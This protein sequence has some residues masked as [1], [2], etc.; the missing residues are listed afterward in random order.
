MRCFILIIWLV[1]ASATRAAA[2]H[3]FIQPLPSGYSH[4][5]VAA[6]TK[7]IYV[8]GQ[9]PVNTLGEV[10]GKGD[11]KAQTEQVYENLKRILTEAGATFNDVVKMTT[12]V[13]NHQPAYLPVIREVRSRYLSKESPPASTLVGVTAL[14][15]PDYL[16]EIEAIA[17]LAK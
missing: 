1:L 15:N 17:V 4:A 11:I 9:V 12:Y 14:A 3:K 8:S 13:V 6:G 10:V 2:Q 7:T 5:V 16:I